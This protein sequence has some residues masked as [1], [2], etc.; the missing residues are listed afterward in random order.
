MRTRLGIAVVTYQRLERFQ[1]VIESVRKLT[2]S[3]YELVVA[4]D[5]GGDETVEWCREQGIRVITGTNRGVC[6]N[7]N[8]GLFC[9]AALGCDV[10]LLLEDD[11]RPAEAG[12]DIDW[13]A[14]TTR[15]HHL[16]YAHPSIEDQV[17]SGQG[18]PDDPFSSPRAS[19]ACTS[20]SLRA[21]EVVGY[22]DARFRGYGIGHREWT[23]RIRRAGYGFKPDDP[24]KG[25][26]HIRG[27]LYLKHGP[28]NRD[29]T[30]VE[31]NRETYRSIRKEPVFRRPWTTEDDREA[32][33][34]EQ[35][36]ADVPFVG[37]G[38]SVM[39]EPSRPHAALVRAETELVAMQLTA[40]VS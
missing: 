4:E 16:A 27:G 30:Q 40:R 33:L 20:I 18:T 8:R 25:N 22:L 21:L 29:E 6:W 11:I 12:W 35:R 26:L 36:D 17:T 24:S 9:L 23:E 34:A 38:L 37:D 2:R 14:A 15:W 1:G 31:A 10:L 32:F 3:P 39:A 28:S 7:K 5:G 13:L 19:G